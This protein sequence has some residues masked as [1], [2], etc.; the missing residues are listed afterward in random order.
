[1]RHKLTAAL[2]TFALGTGA[3]APA[4]ADGAASTRNIILG[5]AAA[6]ALYFTIQNNNKNR[7]SAADIAQ[8][9]Q[10]RRLAQYRAWYRWRN[11]VAATNAQVRNWYYQ[12]FGS[13][14]T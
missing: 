14:P 1:M 13:Y 9:E 3:Y 5:T 10:H 2:L 12:Q 7:A 8:R 4:L 6:A 11:N